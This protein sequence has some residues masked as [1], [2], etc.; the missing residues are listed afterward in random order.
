[1]Y[2][3]RSKKFVE[4]KG[5]YTKRK[6]LYI[7]TSRW[8]LEFFDLKYCQDTE[9]AS[10]LKSES[11]TVASS[12]EPMI[13]TGCFRVNSEP[14][15]LNPWVVEILQKIYS[16]IF[17][18]FYCNPISVSN[19]DLPIK[20]EHQTD[21]SNYARLVMATTVSCQSMRI[22]PNWNSKFEFW[23]QVLVAFQWLES[24]AFNPV[25]TLWDG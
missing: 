9:L 25:K 23:G 20:R 4:S 15:V 11:A 2:A 21:Q 6:K 1:M 22:A 14:F 24:T 3:E 10:Q 19:P 8:N 12:T 7:R 16:W 17:W 13:R 18:L 5:K